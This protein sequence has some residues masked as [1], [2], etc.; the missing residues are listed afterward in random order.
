MKHLIGYMDFYNNRRMHGS[1]KSMSPSEFSK[2]V[3]TLEDRS[4]YHRAM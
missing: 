4:K 2:W 3:M 1:L